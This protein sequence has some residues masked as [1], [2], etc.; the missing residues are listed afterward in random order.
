[1]PNWMS[2]GPDLIQ[3][4]WLKNFSSLHEKVRLQLKEYLDSGFVPSWL[5]KRRSS[6]IQKDNCNSNVASNYRPITCLS[7]IWKLLI[8]VIAD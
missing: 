1:M 7:L 5:T 3:G 6:L 2:P 4:F 8:V